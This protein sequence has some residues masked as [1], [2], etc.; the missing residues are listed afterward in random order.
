MQKSSRDLIIFIISF[1]SSFDISG[2]VVPVYS[3]PIGDWL[4]LMIQGT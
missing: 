1:I 4:S 3:S 2:V